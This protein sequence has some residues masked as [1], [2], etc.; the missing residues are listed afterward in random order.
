VSLR[1][2]NVDHLLIRHLE[3]LVAPLS[4]LRN[5]ARKK[6]LRANKKVAPVALDARD[7]VVRAAGSTYD[8]A[9]PKVEATMEWAVPKVGATKDWAAPKVGATKDW[10]A[11]KVEP[12]VELLKEDVLPRVAGAVA[13]ALAAS[14]PAREEAKSRGTAAVAALRG[15]LAPPPSPRRRRTKR[16]FLLL[17]VLGG[18]Y[19]GWRAWNGQSVSTEPEPWA[20]S[21]GPSYGSSLPTIT[22]PTTDDATGS[23]PEDGLDDVALDDVTLGDVDEDVPAA[24]A[25]TPTTES[26]PPKPARAAKKV[27]DKPQP[28]PQAD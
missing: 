17:T 9:A 26:A 6:A 19:A 1:S 2:S 23:N 18:A 7:N 16:F 5:D 15:E 3:V 22:P 25:I 13:A 10:A 8:W 21:T 20:S 28:G 24:E 4:T 12:A 11:P 14:E 27:S